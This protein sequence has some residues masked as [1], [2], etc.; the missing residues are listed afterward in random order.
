[1]GTLLCW[2]IVPHSGQIKVPLKD[3]LVRLMCTCGKKL[4]KK[5]G[6]A[7]SECA[8]TAREC[9]GV[10]NCRN[11]RG[12]T[13]AVA[14]SAGGGDPIFLSW[15]SLYGGPDTVHRCKFETVHK[16]ISSAYACTNPPSGGYAFFP[17]AS[18]RSDLRNTGE[19][20]SVSHIF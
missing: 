2:V 20:H 7:R 6:G 10:P 4:E 17:R 16:A 8:G 3:F 5:S 9:A 14:R 11:T 13:R 12:A 19:I 1:M 18:S 15:K